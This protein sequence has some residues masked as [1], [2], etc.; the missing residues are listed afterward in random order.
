L[1]GRPTGYLIEQGFGV[2]LWGGCL[3]EGIMPT[4]SEM[5]D[6]LTDIEDELEPMEIDFLES[7]DL[8]GLTD[9]QESCLETLYNNRYLGV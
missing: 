2:L 9:V 7:L 8:D 4:P 3:L 1:N 6:R 5:Y